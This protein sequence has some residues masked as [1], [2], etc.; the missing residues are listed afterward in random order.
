MNL[1]Q[2]GIASI[3]DSNTGYGLPHTA[4]RID[5]TA[6]ETRAQQI[7]SRTLAT[8][9]QRIGEK[10]AQAM[11]ALSENRE[12][13]RGLQQLADLDDHML[14]DVGFSRGDISAAQA[15]QINLG[16]LA[17]RRRESQAGDRLQLQKLEITS[18]NPATDD[19]INEA[20]YSGAN[21]A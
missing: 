19:A 20:L 14:D 15:G 1:L 17:I 3:V 9:A 12:H 4:G 7:R 21:C 18:Q 6:A 10:I 8:L 2:I 13:R 11:Q 5:Y 16:Q